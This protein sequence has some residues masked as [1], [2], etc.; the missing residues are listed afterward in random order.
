MGIYLR[1]TF[2]LVVIILIFFSSTYLYPSDEHNFMSDNGTSKN[3][4]MLDALYF[5]TVTLTTLGYGD[6]LPH[7]N[8]RIFAMAEVFSG[9]LLMGFFL[10]GMSQF[11]N[12]NN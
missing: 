9:V 7:G 10:A 1:D 6:I 3:L 5:S 2:I 12:K 11:Y 4:T 8:F